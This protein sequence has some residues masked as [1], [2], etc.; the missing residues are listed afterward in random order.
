MVLCPFVRILHLDGVT[1]DGDSA[2][3]LQIHVVKY[4]VL[5][6]PSIHCARQLQHAIRQ[7]TFPVVNMRNYTEISYLVH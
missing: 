7:R 3:F 5:H 4:L 2:L 1:L 6:L